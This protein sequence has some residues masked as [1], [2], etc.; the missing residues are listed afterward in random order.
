MQVSGIVDPCGQRD[1]KARDWKIRRPG[2]KRDISIGGRSSATCSTTH[3]DKKVE[4]VFFQIRDMRDDWTRI[5][6]VLAALM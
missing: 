3:F 1:V 2:G 5:R 6:I 4:E